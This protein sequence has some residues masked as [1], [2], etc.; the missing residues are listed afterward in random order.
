MQQVTGN[1]HRTISHGQRKTGI[2]SFFLLRLKFGVTT[3]NCQS[4]VAN[5]SLT[6]RALAFC[7]NYNWCRKSG[8]VNSAKACFALPLGLHL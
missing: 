3:A 1:R 6:F 2:P 5:S 4:L 8:A 7:E